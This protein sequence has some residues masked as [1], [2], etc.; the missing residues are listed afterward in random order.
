MSARKSI[1]WI[2][3][4]FWSI[5]HVRFINAVFQLKIDR[6]FK[7]FI[8]KIHAFLPFWHILIDNRCDVVF[9]YIEPL[10]PHELLVHDHFKLLIFTSVI[11][12]IE[13]F[14]SLRFLKLF[15]F[16]FCIR[17]IFMSFYLTSRSNL[18]LILFVYLSV[19]RF[20][21]D[22]STIY[23]SLLLFILSQ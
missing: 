17:L 21:V 23:N 20:R 4:Y 10:V 18:I 6:I 15:F 5:K 2:S 16:C 19:D 3:Y 12:F 9:C 14:Q 11:V 13:L 1:C 7:I 22:Y 8:E